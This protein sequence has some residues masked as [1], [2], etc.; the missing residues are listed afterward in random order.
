MLSLS[1][2]TEP[3]TCKSKML[4][5]LVLIPTPPDARMRNWLLPVEAKSASV[6]SAQANCPCLF[7]LARP[8]RRK[9]V[10]TPSLVEAAARHGSSVAA[11]GV[12]AAAAYG[13]LLPACRVEDATAH[14]GRVAASDVVLTAA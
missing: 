10:I 11:G 13:C 12:Q 8:P 5:L 7:A 6:E 14:G 3:A 2:P 4:G 1:G 9:A